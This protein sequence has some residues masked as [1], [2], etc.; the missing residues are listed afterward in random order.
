MNKPSDKTYFLIRV[1]TFYTHCHIAN[2]VVKTAKI[3]FRLRKRTQIS[4]IL[5]IKNVKRYCTYL[6]SKKYIKQINYPK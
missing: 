2:T 3:K 4:K 5:W 1:K 6:I